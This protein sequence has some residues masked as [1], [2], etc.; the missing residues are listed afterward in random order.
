MLMNYLS[1]LTPQILDSI[2][3][4]LSENVRLVNEYLMN[5]VMFVRQGAIHFSNRVKNVNHV[6]NTQLAMEVQRWNL[7]KVIG[8]S[9]ETQ[10]MSISALTKRHASEV[11]KILIHQSPVQKAIKVFYVK[12]VCLMM[13]RS[14]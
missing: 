5:H 9:T 12:L 4:L 14:F 3:K 7:M 1:L 6:L 10:L 11:I 13:M 2:F 8:V